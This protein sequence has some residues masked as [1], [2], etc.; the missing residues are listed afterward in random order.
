[1]GNRHRKMTFEISEN[2]EMLENRSFHVEIDILWYQSGAEKINK[3]L[4]NTI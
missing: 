2:Q 3:T 1:M 4:K